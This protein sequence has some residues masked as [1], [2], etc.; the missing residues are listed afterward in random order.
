[1]HL[2]FTLT[3]SADAFLIKGCAAVDLL[4]AMLSQW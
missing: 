1:M 2:T 3:A 4:R